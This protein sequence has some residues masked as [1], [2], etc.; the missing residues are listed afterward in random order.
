MSTNSDFGSLL[1][2]SPDDGIELLLH[3]P[4][5]PYF[6][7]STFT[8][9]YLTN[10]CVTRVLQHMGQIMNKRAYWEGIICM[11]C[12]VYNP[13]YD[14]LE[15]VD[16]LSFWCVVCGCVCVC[17][18]QHFVMRPKLRTSSY[19]IRVYT[20]MLYTRMYWCTI[21]KIVK[22]SRRLMYFS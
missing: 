6:R 9:N 5:N 2:I 12:S 18:D 13:M 14:C 4:D 15:D 21:N 22:S 16:I 7:A 1:T 3:A 8:H 10:V 19:Y 20:R 17:G 11:C